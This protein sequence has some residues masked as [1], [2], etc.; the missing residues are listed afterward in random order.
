MLPESAHVCTKYD[1]RYLL[2]PYS[3][4][5][6]PT[7]ICF[8]VRN[9]SLEH[10]HFQTGALREQSIA[11]LIAKVTPLPGH[12]SDFPRVGTVQ[13][14]TAGYSPV[15]EPGSLT[16]LGTGL[17]GLAGAIRRKCVK[18]QFFPFLVR[19]LSPLAARLAIV[20]LFFCAHSIA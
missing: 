17:I 12:S 18:V 5:C 4:V 14:I 10:V 8:S 19:L 20:R 7:A 15:P 6:H 1:D 11:I 3:Q 16:L 9:R 2:S 13:L